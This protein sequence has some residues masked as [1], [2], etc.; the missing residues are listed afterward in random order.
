MAAVQSTLLSLLVWHLVS[1]VTLC[2]GEMGGG[3]LIPGQK[4]MEVLGCR[5]SRTHPSWPSRC[6]PTEHKVLQLGIASAAEAA[7]KMT[8]YQQTTLRTQLQI[9]VGFTPY[10]L[11]QS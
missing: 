9:F 4:H 6:D 5:V 2:T 3:A 8:V 1:S 7:R 10:D 11:A